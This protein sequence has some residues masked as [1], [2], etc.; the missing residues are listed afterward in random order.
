MDSCFTINKLFSKVKTI[1]WNGPLGAFEYKPF[2]NST[3]IVSKFLAA[4]V[5]EYNL[6]VVLGGGD[7]IASLKNL[8]V[9]DKFSYVSNSGGAFLELLEGK[10]LPGIVALQ[11]NKYS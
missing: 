1:L 11:S 4:K 10:K 5:K 8:D 7:T 6:N 3:K 2:D 9:I